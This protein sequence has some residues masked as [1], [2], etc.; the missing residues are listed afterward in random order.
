MSNRKADQ[1]YAHDP[2]YPKPPRWSRVYDK[3]CPQHTDGASRH[4]KMLAEWL[5][6]PKSELRRFL[7]D[8]G[9]E[10]DHWASN[11]ETTVKALWEARAE[12]DRLKGPE[13][14][15]KDFEAAVA[16]MTKRM[17]AREQRGA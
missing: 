10:P 11:L 3:H 12:I 16:K 6:D 17:K 14:V 7:V 5:R 4:A 15:Q 2:D 8:G 13:R 9:W 1:R